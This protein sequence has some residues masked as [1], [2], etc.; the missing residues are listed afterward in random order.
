MKTLTALLRLLA[1]ITFGACLGFALAAY[2]YHGMTGCPT[3]I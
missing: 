2:L 1:Y 3:F